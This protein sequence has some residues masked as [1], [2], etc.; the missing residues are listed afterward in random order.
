M[1]IGKLCMLIGIGKLCMGDVST[2]TRAFRGTHTW[3]H[4]EGGTQAYT[5]QSVAVSRPETARR[6]CV[7]AELW[8]VRARA[9]GPVCDEVASAGGGTKAGRGWMFE[10]R[11]VVHATVLYLGNACIIWGMGCGWT[12]HVVLR[13][14][15]RL[16]HFHSR[17]TLSKVLRDR[18]SRTGRNVTTAYLENCLP[19]QMAMRPLVRMVCSESVRRCTIPFS[20]SIQQL[21][22]LLVWSARLGARASHGERRHRWQLSEGAQRQGCE[23]LS[24]ATSA[25]GGGTGAS[26]WRYRGLWLRR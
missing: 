26:P 13:V 10:L 16:Y 7:R 21:R 5:I 2:G 19:S 12:F 17:L 9:M 8:P 4:G 3:L 18:C 15:P 22:T 24:A 20:S 23:P 25:T 11:R 6:E 1:L 14:V